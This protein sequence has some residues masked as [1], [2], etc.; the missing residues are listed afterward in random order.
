M[1]WRRKWQPIPVFSPGKSHGQK[2]V[3]GSS[4]WGHKESDTTEQLST[5]TKQRLQKLRLDTIKQAF[6]KLFWT[7]VPDTWNCKWYIPFW[8]LLSTSSLLSTHPPHFCLTKTPEFP[9]HWH[10]MHCDSVFSDVLSPLFVTSCL[11]LSW[12]CER[13]AVYPSRLSSLALSVI[14]ACDP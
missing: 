9:E 2:S 4:P 6:V 8:F 3:V 10:A 13:T 5:E 1:P 11:L 7:Q 14:I 12:V